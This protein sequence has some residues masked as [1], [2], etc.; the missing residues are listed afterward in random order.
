MNGVTLKAVDPT[1]EDHLGSGPKIAAFV[2]MM[3]ERASIRF[4]SR[5][6][7]LDAGVP[8][9]V[10]RHMGCDQPTRTR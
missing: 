8:T 6:P 3:A 9:T 5:R 2:G 7:V 1:A 4:I 10:C